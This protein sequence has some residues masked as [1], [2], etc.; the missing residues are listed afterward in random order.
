M[1]PGV[2]SIVP[3]GSGVDPGTR[4]TQHDGFRDPE[5]ERGVSGVGWVQGQPGNQY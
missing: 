1:D 5:V 2:V 4:R 3:R